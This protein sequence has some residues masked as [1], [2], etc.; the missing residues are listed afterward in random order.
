M[1]LLEQESNDAIEK[2]VKV[3]QTGNLRTYKVNLMNGKLIQMF[4][5]CW[6]SEII[7]YY[8]NRLDSVDVC[9]KYKIGDTLR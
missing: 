1:R 2:S 4:V 3:T 9:R 7:Y 5:R 8:Y 6:V